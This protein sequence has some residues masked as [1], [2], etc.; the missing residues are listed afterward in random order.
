MLKADETA[1]ATLTIRSSIVN[2]S[3]T[4]AESASSLTI[5]GDA[6]AAT[7]TTNGETDAA[8]QPGQLLQYI[9]TIKNQATVPLKDVKVDV[10][11]GGSLLD[12][13]YVQAQGGSLAP[14]QPL[15]SWTGVGVPKLRVIEPNDTVTLQMVLRVKQQVGVVS[16]ASSTVSMTVTSP[17]VPA[18]T[19]AS[20]VIARAESKMRLA[21]SVAFKA[22]GYKVDPLGQIKNSGPQPP[23]VGV[24]SQYVIRWSIQP[25]SAALK[26]VVVVGKLPP[27]VTYTGKV[28]GVPSQ[29]LS[30]DARTGEVTWSLG[31]AKANVTIAAA[32]QVEVTPAPNQ[33]GRDV[34]LI[35]DSKL[36]ATDDFTGLK[37]SESDSDIT[38][39]LRGAPKQGSGTVVQ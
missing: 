38:T 33:E 28:A 12:L 22:M 3:R 17:T 36:S 10:R 13:K 20:G 31:A 16:G 32:F 37:V 9:L 39:A 19:S 25:S 27:G 1:P 15:I 6:L 4:L 7:I 29:Q 8:V 14:T 21:A 23:K 24:K 11:L 34:V 2:T 18:G 30:F 35:G 5:P 26:D